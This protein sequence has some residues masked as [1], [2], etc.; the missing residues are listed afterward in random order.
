MLEVF[1]NIYNLLRNDE[2]LMRLLWYPPEDIG[3]GVPHPFDDGVPNIVDLSDD[4][5]IG[6]YWRIVDTV[7]RTSEK[8]T[9]IE[10]DAMCRLYI[11][12]GRRR[13][14][15][16]NYTLATQ[17]VHID[18]FVHESYSKDFRME[19]INDRLCEL[20]SLERIQ[21][22]IGRVDYAAGQ[23]WQAPIGYSKYQHRFVFGDG[24]K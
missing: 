18:V 19:R 2:V 6:I 11:Y 12:P 23:G 10:E 7:I 21:G 16:N 3:K 15:F 13:P 4:D 20:L 24:K 14:V 17:E 5:H 22:A 8:V 1:S 9:D